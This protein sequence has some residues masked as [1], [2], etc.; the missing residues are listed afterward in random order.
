VIAAFLLAAALRAQTVIESIVAKVDDTVILYSE[1]LQEGALLNLENGAPVQT[2]L[3]PDLKAKILDSLV[4]RAMLLVEARERALP[5]DERKVAEML[6]TYEKLPYLSDLLKRFELTPTEFRTVVKRRLAA[7][8]ALDDH[9][10]RVFP[11]GRAA[12]TD[13][14]KRAATEKW[15]DTLRRKHR[16]VYFAIP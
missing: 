5:V 15:V 16:I 13:E 1:L 10:S 11:A 6:A 7:R 2:P 14:Q 8:A 4:V 3:S 12:P 9:L